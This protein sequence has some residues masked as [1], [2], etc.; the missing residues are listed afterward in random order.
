M[1]TTKDDQHIVI[2]DPK[3][4]EW[5]DRVSREGDFVFDPSVTDG[6][7]V[8]WQEWSVPDMAWDASRIWLQ[9]AGRRAQGG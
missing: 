8:A 2:V 5:P 7:S 4:E 9:D 3:G 6:V 1:V